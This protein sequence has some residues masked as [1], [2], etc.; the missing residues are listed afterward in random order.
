MGR[1]WAFFITLREQVVR[2]KAAEVPNND[3]VERLFNELAEAPGIIERFL[4]E[5]R[6]ELINKLRGV[7]L[8]LA[9]GA[10]Q[11]DATYQSALGLSNGRPSATRI[12]FFWIHRPL[13][14]YSQ[15]ARR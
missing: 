5:R 12:Y 3:R 14:L 11:A 1:T 2:D 4:Q 8:I 13:A 15:S 9:S 10:S 6:E 7:Q